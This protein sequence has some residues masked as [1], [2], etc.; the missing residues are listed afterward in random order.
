MS[1]TLTHTILQRLGFEKPNQQNFILPGFAIGVTTI[2][3]S[4]AEA[5]LLKSKQSLSC[6]CCNY[7]KFLLHCRSWTLRT[8]TSRTSSYWSSL[9]RSRL[10]L[11]SAL[12]Q[13]S[14]CRWSSLHHRCHNCHHDCICTGDRPERQPPGIW[15]RIVHSHHTR[16]GDARWVYHS[17]LDCN[18]IIVPREDDHCDAVRWRQS[19]PRSS[20]QKR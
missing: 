12:P 20:K 6:C 7:L 11:G 13:L 8:R 19:H 16:G 1:S 10:K 5:G 9:P 15:E 3:Y 14:E 2:S 4:F 17:Q 18:M